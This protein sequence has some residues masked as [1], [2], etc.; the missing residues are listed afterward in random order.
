[1]NVL[2]AEKLEQSGI[3]GLKALGCTVLSDPG[4]A[5]EAIPGAVGASGAQVLI[6][7]GKKVPGAVIR[8]SRGLKL[9]VR[10]GAGYDTIDVGAASTAGVAVCN[11]PGMNSVAVAELAMG[12]LLACDRRIPEGTASLR[13]GAWNKKEFSKARGLK[14]STLGVIGMGAIGQE[15]AKRAKAF[16]MTI[17]GWSVPFSPAEAARLGVE[18]GGSDRASILAMLPRCDAVTVHV[19]ALDQTLRMCDSQFFGAMKKGAYFINTSRGSV[20]DEAALRQAIQENGIRAGLDV[21]ENEP[22]TP[23]AAWQCPTVTLPGVAATH[24]IGAST[25]QAQEAVAAET[26]RIV[27]VFKETG[28]FENCVNAAALK[29]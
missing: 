6:V 1:V 29:R 5:P 17:V 3:D 4:L 26:V 9:I 23:E 14:G 24:H 28:R 18:F 15:V 22:G 13:A 20:V 27:K 11:C 21:F 12:L 25:D 16:D 8:D 19:A 2:I 10:A 7:R